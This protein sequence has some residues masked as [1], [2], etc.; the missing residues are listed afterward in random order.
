MNIYIY[1]NKFY[2]ILHTDNIIQTAI[3][4]LLVNM[5]GQRDEI[6]VESYH[7]SSPRLSTR[8]VVVNVN[9]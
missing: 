7:I 2:H 8:Q 5:S 6:Y 3:G 9:I 1:I 4:I